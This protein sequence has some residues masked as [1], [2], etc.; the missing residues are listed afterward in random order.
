MAMA[1]MEAVRRCVARRGGSRRRGGAR[2]LLRC[3]R[4]ARWLRLRRAVATGAFGRSGER[5]PGEGRNERVGERC[6]ASRGVVRSIQSDEG[7]TG[8]QGGRRWRGAAVRARRA[9]AVPL[10][11]RKTTEEGGPG[12]LGRLLAG[13]ACCGWAAQGGAP[14]K[15]LL[16]FIFVF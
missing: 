6:G 15:P 16:L 9:R 12:G 13:P 3:S 1:A 10:S 4:G 2:G 11:G 7:R 14:G 8:R 5:E